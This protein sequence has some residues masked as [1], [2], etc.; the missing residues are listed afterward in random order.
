LSVG[1]GVKL[2]AP[3]LGTLGSAILGEEDG[4]SNG[5]EVGFMLGLNEGSN[6]G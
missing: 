2:T 3:E 4:K 5:C 1:I 6:V